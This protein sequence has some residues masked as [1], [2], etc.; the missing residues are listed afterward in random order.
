MTERT[1]AS[2]LTWLQKVQFYIGSG[3]RSI[4]SGL[5]NTAFIKY[6]TDFIGLD[7]KWMGYVYIVFTV[8]AAIND[9][10]FGQ[11][12]DKRPY[13][14]GIGK[15]GPAFV[16]SIPFW[17]VITLAFPWAS[18]SWSQLGI[19]IYLFFALT[20]WE[21]AGTVFG[22]TYSAIATNLFLTTK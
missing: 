11:W 3:G 22:I 19:S 4:L 21:T 5:V 16:R 1:G 13:R 14:K 9:P 17:V 8:W 6:Y 20:L 2:G 7:P 15:Y 12:L 18:P 10:I